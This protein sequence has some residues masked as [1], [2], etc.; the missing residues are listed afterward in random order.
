VQDVIRAVPNRLHLVANARYGGASYRSLAAD[1]PV[2]GGKPLWPDDSWSGSTFTFRAGA[3]VLSGVEGL[4]FTGNI[5]RGYRAPS[6]TDLGTTGLTG[7][8]YSVSATTVAGMNAMIGTTAGATAVST[9]LPVVQL[10]A[11]TSLSY[12]GGVHYRRKALS[13]DFHAFVNDLSDNVVYQSLILPQGAVGA[14]LGDQIISAQTAGGAVFVPAS[15]SPVLVR[16]NY[17][18]A[19]I[20]GVEYK[21]DWNV[22]RA[23]TLGA[24]FTYLHAADRASGLPPNIEGGTPAPDGYLKLR[25][26]K[27]GSS[28]WA[29]AYVHAAATQ[30]RLSTLDLEDRRTGATRTRSN[31]KNF[32][33][34]GAAVRGW[35]V[36][37]PDGLAGNADDLLAVTGETLAQVQNRVLGT[38]AS[39]PLYTSVAGYTTV[40]VRGGFTVARRHE[41]T[42]DFENIGDRNY[43]GIAWGIDAPGRNLAVTWRTRF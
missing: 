5:S 38:A 11:E 24:V 19:R 28:W 16:A 4:T 3:V 7:S 13:T 30:D 35:V 14:P 43:R 36:P 21:L 18:D 15:S 26:M 17:G 22:A 29:E 32:F 27:P 1:S 9:G 39:A 20:Y 37:G 40:G 10:K 41:V 8:G 6:I 23:W 42:V 25:Y 31:I 12:E 33:Y 34:N 2:V